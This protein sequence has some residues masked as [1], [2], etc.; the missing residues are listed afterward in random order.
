[1]NT[2]PTRIDPF[3][4]ARGGPFYELQRRLG[5]LREDA[6]RAG[7]RAVL[8]VALAWGV[9]LLLSLLAGHAFGPFSE[10][11][12]LLDFVVWARFFIAIGL[13]MLMERQVEER[14]RIHLIHFAQ[15]PL[16]A[17]G[18]FEAAAKAVNR[19]LQRRNALPAE[20]ICLLIAIIAT[21]AVL[22]NLLDAETSSWAVRVSAA[23]TS[24]TAAAWWCLIVSSPLF[25]FLLLRWLWRHLVW[26]LLLRELAALDLRLVVTH[27][28]G[29]GGLAFVGEYPNAYTIFVFAVSCVIGAAIA[30]QLLL[31]DLSA[32][33]FGYVMGV[34]L[35]IVLAFFAFPLQAFSKPLKNLKGQTL[36]ISSARATRH[37][38]AAERE[39]LGRNMSAAEDAEPVA[40]SEIADP[41]KTYTA[42]KKLSVF[43]I[44]RS[45][46]LPVSAAA[47]LPLVA[48]GATQLPVK[49][50][51]S[52]LK[53]LLLL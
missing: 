50:L 16:L 14:L 38:R 22:L 15:A 29:H 51:F 3:L 52:L 42:A 19:A 47:L 33:T 45:A 12:F 17:P 41:S 39:L 32:T 1:M 11:P 40:A 34:W 5:L 8:F 27:P 44:D 18:S 9:P 48:A 26:S 24:L 7:S 25:G 4:V 10:K 36:L 2:E 31:G 35:V 28:D 53:R 13:F 37:M 30:H 21:I 49:Q 23:G 20:L 6:F 43:L 46:L